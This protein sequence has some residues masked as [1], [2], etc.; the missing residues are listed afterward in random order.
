MATSLLWFSWT[1]QQLFKTSVMNQLQDPLSIT[2]LKWNINNQR[3]EHQG[4]S[5]RGT[6]EIVP[7]PANVSD[8][9]DPGLA[10]II[11]T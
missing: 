8:A 3:S 11:N 10:H 4:P 9:G 6:K 5:L 1:I 7:G 2:D